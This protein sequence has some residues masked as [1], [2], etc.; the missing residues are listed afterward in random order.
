MFPTTNNEIALYKNVL[1][2]A[3]GIYFSANANMANAEKPT[4]TKVK[5]TFFFLFIMSLGI[6]MPH[7]FS[8]MWIQHS[9]QVT[10]A[11][12]ST[13]VSRQLQAVVRLLLLTLLR[14]PPKERTC[15]SRSA[16][17]AQQPLS[18]SSAPG[19]GSVEPW[20]LTDKY[21]CQAPILPRM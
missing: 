17:P 6:I 12:D 16:R 14:E 21:L 9:S 11:R 13:R 10:G 15:L 1:N 4:A 3:V 8:P 19:F 2:N 20:V 7:L 5:Y 18:N